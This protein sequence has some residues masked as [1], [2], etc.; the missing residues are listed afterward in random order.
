MI[1]VGGENIVDLIQFDEQ[2]GAPVFKGLVGGSPFNVAFAI[3]RQNVPVGYLSPLSTDRF[4]DAFSHTLDEAGVEIVSKRAAAPSS[5]AVVTLEN[6]QPAYS[7]YR[8]GTSERMADFALLRNKLADAEVQVIHT[9]SLAIAQ[10]A[11]ADEWAALYILGHDQGLLTSLDPNIR[12]LL[13]DDRPAYFVRLE[14]MLKKTDVLKLSDED[15]EWLFPD[16]SQ[17]EA[18]DA[19]AE[20]TSAAIVV[21]TRGGEGCRARTAHGDF[22]VDAHPVRQLA[23][24]VGAGDTFMATMLTGL[25]KIGC[26]DRSQLEHV[27]QDD[28]RALLQRAGK[29]A[30]LNCEHAGCNPPNQAQLDGQS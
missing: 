30:A 11:D 15:L 16:L 7:I 23:D 1:L 29:A 8:N 21:L 27:T 17:D 12:A 3:G 18:F 24:T 26:M 10:G 22:S 28:W 5:M 13:I 19:I 20:K 14:K 4:G 9:G 6:G 25:Y 2:A